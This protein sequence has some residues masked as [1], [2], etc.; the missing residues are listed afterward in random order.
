L[1]MFFVWAV[2]PVILGLIF[3]AQGGLFLGRKIFQLGNTFGWERIWGAFSAV[4]FGVMGF[5]LSRLIGALGANT[6]GANLASGLFPFA[7]NE[8]AWWAFVWL[9]A[10]AAGGALAGA[11]AGVLTDLLGRLTGLMD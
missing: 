4:G 10:G 8:S 11:L 9:M 1:G 5:G 2:I 6:I 7:A 3:G